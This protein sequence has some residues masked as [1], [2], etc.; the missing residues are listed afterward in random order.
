MKSRTSFFNA[1]VLKKDITRFSPVWILYTVILLLRLPELFM[2]LSYRVSTIK[3]DLSSAAIFNMIYAAVVAAMVFGD[4]YKTRLCYSQHAMPLR[5]EGWFLTHC[6]AGLLFSL[7]PNLLYSIISALLLKQYYY[8]ALVWLAVN[9]MQYLF[10]FGLAVFCAMCAGSRLGMVAIYGICNYFATLLIWF[11]QEVF[12]S[13]LHGVVWEPEWVKFLTP[14]FAMQDYYLDI[15]TSHFNNIV[16]IN[17]VKAPEIWVYTALVAVIGVALGFFAMLLYRKRNLEVA[18]DLLAL[19]KL[20]PVFW[21]IAAVSAESILFGI[22]YV[23]F[24][25][26]IIG[27]M[28]A[29]MLTERTV[30]VLRWKKIRWA[31]LMAGV[32]LACV[33]LT[34]WDPLG[35]HLYV[36]KASEIQALYF[37]EGDFKITDTAEMEEYLQLHKGLTKYNDG[38]AELETDSSVLRVEFC[39]ELKNGKEIRR[40]YTLDAES[41]WGKQTKKLTSHWKYVF[42]TDDWEAFLASVKMV[43]IED[44]TVLQDGAIVEK[45]IGH[46]QMEELLEA[47]RLDCEEGN[48]S[49]E[50]CFHQNDKNSIRA[51]IRMFTG[52]SGAGKTVTIYEDCTH[53]CQYL[54]SLLGDVNEG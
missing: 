52:W 31:L 48:M 4:L 46:P 34:V 15:Q 18:G 43:K 24:L 14:I 50:W 12:I 45:G 42:E 3:Y 29:M 23:P 5:R 28:A 1:T 51:E 8:I 7:V 21:V 44:Q 2:G 10:F 47:M 6:T 49:Q 41:T 25:G 27:F 30:K 35:I 38:F 40:Q 26:L 9:T 20:R 53:T 36:P 22:T 37:N 13:I 32:Y 33:L 19:P 16:E 11:V 17:G 39:Y 54:D